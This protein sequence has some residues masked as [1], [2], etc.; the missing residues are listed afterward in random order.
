MLAAATGGFESAYTQSLNLF[1]TTNSMGKVVDQQQTTS[2][3]D[4]GAGNAEDEDIRQKLGWLKST[5][6][7]MVMEM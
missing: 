6:P 1:C 7:D 5:R 2:P 3:T 4:G